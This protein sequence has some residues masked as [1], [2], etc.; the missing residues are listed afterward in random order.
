MIKQKQRKNTFLIPKYLMMYKCVKCWNTAKKS[1][2]KVETDLKN[3][4]E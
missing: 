3:V 1:R 4:S 2:E